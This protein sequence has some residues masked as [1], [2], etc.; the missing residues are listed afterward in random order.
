MFGFNFHSSEERFSMEFNE[1]KKEHIGLCDCEI[2]R[3]DPS[4]EW[5]ELALPTQHIIHVKFQSQ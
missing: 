5:E 1:P 3:K 2:H 4:E